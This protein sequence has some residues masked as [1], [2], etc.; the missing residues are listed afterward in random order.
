[1]KRR[2]LYLFT[3]L[4]VVMTVS[5][6]KESLKDLE[7][8]QEIQPKESGS[9][10]TM[11]TKRSDGIIRLSL[12]AVMHERPTVWIDLNGDGVR[13]TDASE[14][15]KIFNAYSEYRMAS[16]IT[17]VVIHGNVTSLHA[18]SN[19]L[20]ELTI[21]GNAH[22]KSLGVPYNE[23]TDLDVSRNSALENLDI[24]NNKF[25]SL[26]LSSASNLKSLWCFNNSLNQ[27]DLTKCTALTSLDCSGNDLSR[28]D[29]SANVRLSHLLA[30]NN[31]FTT[32]DVSRNPSLRQLWLFGNHF[33][34]S[35]MRYIISGLSK[36]TQGDLWLTNN[37]VEADLREM[38]GK[39]GWNMD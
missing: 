1:M 11:V 3:L 33:T 20:T 37:S 10:I 26:E 18:A 38:A 19:H 5:C 23:L 25:S 7:V 22:L 13:A 17:R 29:I 9:V 36:T 24:S 31:K 32:L 34:A 6:Q 28:L 15:V 4:L 39:K 27:V 30:Y 2:Y 8:P 12:D 14:D 21:S 35:E 16:G